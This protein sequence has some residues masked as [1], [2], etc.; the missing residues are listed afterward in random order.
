MSGYLFMM[1]GEQICL[2]SRRPKIV[3]ISTCYA[4]HIAMSAACKEVISLMRVSLFVLRIEQDESVMQF[5]S[6][7]QSSI[8]MFRKY[9]SLK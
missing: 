9:Q 6:H 5:N 8:I 1:V 2:A 7:S 3:E 4:E